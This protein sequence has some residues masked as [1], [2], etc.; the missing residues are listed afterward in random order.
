[1]RGGMRWE[2][3]VWGGASRFFVCLTLI[4]LNAHP[5]HIA[6]L[7]PPAVPLVTSHRKEGVQIKLAV[8]GLATATAV[9][10]GLIGRPGPQDRVAVA[11]IPRPLMLVAQDFVG[12][13]NFLEPVG[14]LVRVVL[15]F[16]CEGE[17]KKEGEDARLCERE[18][19]AE[20]S[21]FPLTPPHTH[22]HTPGCHCRAPLR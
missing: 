19:R 14:R 4:S 11:V 15:V 3:C 9:T 6:H 20:H 17:K 1:M 8:R 22:K 16:V 2:V 5:S 21:H 10:A 7:G 18:A 12:I 13:L